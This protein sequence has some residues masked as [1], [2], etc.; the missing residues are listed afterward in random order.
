MIYVDLKGLGWILLGLSIGFTLYQCLSFRKRVSPRFI[1]EFG[2]KTEILLMKNP[3]VQDYFRHLDHRL[4]QKGQNYGVKQKLNKYVFIMICVLTGLI[5]GTG[6]F[7]ILDNP[8]ASLLLFIVGY[9]IPVFLLNWE[10][11]YRDRKLRKQIPYF[12]MTLSNFY[13]NSRDPLVAIAECSENVKEPLKGI[14]SQMNDQIKYG[15]PVSEIFQNM[16]LKIENRLLADFFTDLETQVHY[17]G[18]FN[19]VLSSYIHQ[20]FEHEFN[21]LERQGE[22]TAISQVSYFLFAVFVFLIFSMVKVQPVAMN[23]LVTTFAGKVAVVMMLVITMIVFFLLKR[24][25][26]MEGD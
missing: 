1:R 5:T 26:R 17:G 18:D 14:L 9:Q 11:S 7:L 3:K 22:V 6:A 24:M 4:E 25:K 12:F 13:Q 20:S 8:A 23:L 15:F 19:K 10:K 21:R 16:K 2:R